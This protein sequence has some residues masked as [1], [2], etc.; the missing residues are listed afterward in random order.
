MTDT[1]EEPL[2]PRLVETD[3]GLQA[4]LG[5][6]MTGWR[7]GFAAITMPLRPIHMNRYGIPHGGLYGVMLDTVMGFAGSYTGDP[8]HRVFAMTLSLT[9]NFL[10][11][12]QTDVLIAEGHRV[13]GGKRTFFAE[14][15]VRDDGGT[16]VA[17]GSGVFRYRQGAVR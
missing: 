11:R 8:D 15:V 10:S 5:Y 14:A 2:D 17:K 6:V 4:T 9:T 1:A 16:V 3:Y 12:P 7:E 13:G